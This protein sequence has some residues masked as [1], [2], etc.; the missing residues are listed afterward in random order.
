MAELPICIFKLKK[1]SASMSI[2]NFK[3][4]DQ[5]VLLEMIC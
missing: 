3:I 4:T 2:K 5:L 1:K